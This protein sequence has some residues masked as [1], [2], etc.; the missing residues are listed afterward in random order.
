MDDID[1]RRAIAKANEAV[2]LH[3]RRVAQMVKDQ[4]FGG[5]F[6]IAVWKA[7]QA[8]KERDHLIREME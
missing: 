6:D 3:A 5:H 7:D 4:D 8:R 2:R 1:K